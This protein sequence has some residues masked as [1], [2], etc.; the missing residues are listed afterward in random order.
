M[1][2]W[3]GEYG[4]AR[5]LISAIDRMK[6]QRSE[7]ARNLEAERDALSNADSRFREVKAEVKSLKLALKQMQS[8]AAALSK[9]D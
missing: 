2:D 8:E 1:N 6:V 3:G 7:L 5:D 4:Q 9:L